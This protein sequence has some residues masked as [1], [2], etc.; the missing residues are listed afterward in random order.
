MGYGRHLN[1]NSLQWLIQHL[2]QVSGYFCNLPT[3][4]VEII[5][6]VIALFYS[7]DRGIPHCALLILPSA[8]AFQLARWNKP[9]SPPLA[10]CSG[11]SPDKHP[12]PISGSMGWGEGRKPCCISPCVQLPLM[13]FVRWMLAYS[14]QCLYCR[15]SLQCS[16][17]LHTVSSNHVAKTIRTVLDTLPASHAKLRHFNILALSQKYKGHIKECFKRTKLH[18]LSGFIF[19]QLP[20]LQDCLYQAHHFAF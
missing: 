5:L 7:I 1:G 20:S 10:C 17:C 4:P 18:I 11:G 12:E 14:L 16:S 15:H 9:P 3:T 13:E 19:F 6:H 8:Q 2:P